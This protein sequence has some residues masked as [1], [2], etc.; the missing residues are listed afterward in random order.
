MSLQGSKMVPEGST[1]P[2]G[3]LTTQPTT[4]TARPCGPGVVS[5]RTRPSRPMGTAIRVTVVG[6]ATNVA[7]A[8]TMARA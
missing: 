4:L 5:I 8:D 6:P 2:A 7:V 1:V 3:A